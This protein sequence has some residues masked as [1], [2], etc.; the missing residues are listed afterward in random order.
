MTLPL[1]KPTLYKF[2]RYSS[3]RAEFGIS[4]PW[5]PCQNGRFKEAAYVN[6]TI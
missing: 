3:Q 2:A 5:I 6:I 4:D 1:H